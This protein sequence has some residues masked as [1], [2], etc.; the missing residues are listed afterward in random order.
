MSRRAGPPAVDSPDCRDRCF[1]PSLTGLLMTYL[2][3]LAQRTARLRA[4]PLIGLGLALAGCNGDHLTST[5]EPEATPSSQTPTALFSV[6]F[7]GGIP[8]G[9]WA[10]PT[11]WFGDTYNGAVRNIM[12]GDLLSELAAIK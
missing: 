4:L 10:L 7:R 2:F 9:I 5:S 3:K 12:P 11:S 8:F 6:G 1:S